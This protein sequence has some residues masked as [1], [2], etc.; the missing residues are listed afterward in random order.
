MKKINFTKAT[1][2]GFA[3]LALAACAPA[4]ETPVEENAMPEENGVMMEETPAAETP[5]EEN[6][7]PEE[8]GAMEMED[9]E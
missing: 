2:A 9:A 6:A 1:A 4:A 8:N 3:M 7:M 5:V